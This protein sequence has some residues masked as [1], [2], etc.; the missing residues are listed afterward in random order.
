MKEQKITNMK[1]Y[2]FHHQPKNKLCNTI[3]WGI[4]LVLIAFSF[5]A[6]YFDVVIAEELNEVEE[7]SFSKNI[8]PVFQASCT[9]CHNGQVTSPDFTRTSA[10][11][12]LINGNYISITNPET[13]TLITKIQSGHPYTGSVTDTEINRIVQWI[14]NGALNN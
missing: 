5:N 4:L 10:Y 8:V 11:A 14:K 13:S 3:S 9:S 2:P 1:F 12:E 7:I 6:C